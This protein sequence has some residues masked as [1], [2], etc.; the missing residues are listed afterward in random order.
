[1]DRTRVT[2]YATI[3]HKEAN[4]WWL[5]SAQTVHPDTTT[6]LVTAVSWTRLS[7]FS[8]GVLA[9]SGQEDRFGNRV[10][11]V[12]TLNRAK[13]RVTTTTTYPSVANPSISVSVN[14]ILAKMDG[15]NGRSVK[16]VYDGFDRLEK[17]IDSR[18]GETSYTY[19]VLAGNATNQVH[20]VTEVHTVPA[21]TSAVV[22]ATYDYR[23]D[24]RIKSVKNAGDHFTY[25][26]YDCVGRP[27]R[28][29]GGAVTPVE[30]VYNDYGEM[31]ELRTFRSG[32]WTVSVTAAT[33]RTALAAE[34]LTSKATRCVL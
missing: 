33:V 12:T 11:T 2:D 8:N 31:S 26:D 15:T 28:Q 32:T 20:T 18:T 29:W 27:T 30:Y 21:P 7:G 13:R 19:R 24:G 6:S 34:H 1:M 9:E 25:Y 16:Q 17:Q 23:D 3:F 14:G 22:V 4:D 5:R 10:N